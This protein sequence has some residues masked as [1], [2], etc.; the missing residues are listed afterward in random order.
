MY[1][2]VGAKA[3]ERIIRRL[4]GPESKSPDDARVLRIEKQK[5]SLGFVTQRPDI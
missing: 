5:G 3:I 4:H 2:D 1:S